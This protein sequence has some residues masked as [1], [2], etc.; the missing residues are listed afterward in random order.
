MKFKKTCFYP[1]LPL[2]QAT[3]AFGVSEQLDCCTY[4]ICGGPAVC[5]AAREIKKR[6][7]A[8]IQPVDPLAQRVI[9]MAPQPNV[10]MVQQPPTLQQQ[11]MVQQQPVAQHQPPQMLSLASMAPSAPTSAPPSNTRHEFCTKCGE[12]FQGGDAFCVGCGTPRA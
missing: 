3:G 1:S 12:A 6:K 5:R 10:M 11:P 2:L 7:A 4:F 9:M 8:G